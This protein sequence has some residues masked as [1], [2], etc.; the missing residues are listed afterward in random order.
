MRDIPRWPARV[1]ALIGL[2][3]RRIANA[4]T[5]SPYVPFEADVLSTFT[6][7]TVPDGWQQGRENVTTAGTYSTWQEGD[8]PSGHQM[9]V[10]LEALNPDDANVR[11]AAGDLGLTAVSEPE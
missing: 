2:F 3:R 5:F 9:S 11:C 8:L 10:R 4:R 7:G 1:I 6:V